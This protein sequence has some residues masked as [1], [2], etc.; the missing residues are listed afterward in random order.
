MNKWYTTG[1][2]VK[3]RHVAKVLPF[4]SVVIS[5]GGN[6]HV[7]GHVAKDAERFSQTRF[8]CDK[9]GLPLPAPLRSY[10]TPAAPA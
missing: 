10:D 1:Q 6:A 3:V 7:L 5:A 8:L 9:Y 4:I 2:A